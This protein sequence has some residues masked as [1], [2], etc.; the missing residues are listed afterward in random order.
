MSG[1]GGVVHCR[2]VEEDGKTP[3]DKSGVTLVP[4]E[5]R[6]V[7][8]LP[9]LPGRVEHICW[10]QHDVTLERLADSGAGLVI[11]VTAQL[12]FEL[13]VE[14]GAVVFYESVPAGRTRYVLTHLDRSD[15]RQ[16]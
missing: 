15:V 9:E 11:E 4:A 7:W 1:R 16:V 6:V 2:C 8:H 14:A 5:N 12:P 13:E 10:G 3:L